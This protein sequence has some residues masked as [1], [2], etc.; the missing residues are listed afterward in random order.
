MRR[1]RCRQ[2]CSGAT[3]FSGAALPAHA[4]AVCPPAGAL[5]SYK[6]LDCIRACVRAAGVHSNMRLDLALC[7]G[8]CSHFTVPPSPPTLLPP[9]TRMRRMWVR[10]WRL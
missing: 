2:L 9:G 4:A 3:T 7:A 6:L 8:V 10:C 5:V 1:W